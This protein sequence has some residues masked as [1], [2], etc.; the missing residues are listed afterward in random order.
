LVEHSFPCK[1]LLNLIDLVGIYFNIVIDLQGDVKI[2]DWGG[3]KK[4][5]DVTDQF[6]F[7]AEDTI[8]A[9]SV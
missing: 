8:W 6:S 1:T 7:L 2:S 9:G 3:R 5:K 4:L